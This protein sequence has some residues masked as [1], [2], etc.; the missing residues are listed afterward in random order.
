MAWSRLQSASNTVGSGNGTVTF[1]TN[2]SAGSKIICYIC[3]SVTA[4]GTNHMTSV[5]LNDTAVT[6][7][8]SLAAHQDTAD[9]SWVYLYA[10]DT[11]ADAVGTK[12]TITAT[13]GITDFGI[14][15]LAQ[16]VSGLLAGSTS[17][18][19]DGTPA[20]DSG[21]T[22]GPA[23]TGSYS[24]NASNE[25]LVA[26]Y[27]DPG[28]GVTVTNSSGYTPDANNVNANSD[29]T[30]FVDYKNSGQ[31]AES[32][33]WALS[34]TA[35]WNTILVAFKLAASGPSGP[36]DVPQVTPGQTWLSLFKP[37]Q[38][39]LQPPA[40]PSG[41]Y[42][43]NLPNRADV[44][45]VS[46][47]AAWLRR[48]KPGLAKPP[49]Q[50][51]DQGTVSASGSFALAPLALSGQGAQSSPDVPQ[52]Q[53]GPVWLRLLRPWARPQVPP[54][55]GVQSAAPVTSTGSLALAPLS[56]SGSGGQSSPDVP[57]AQPGPLWLRLFKPGLPKPPPQPPA[58]QAVNA[59]G[60][61]TLASLALSGQGGQS[62]PDQPQAAPGPLWFRLFK[63]WAQ[64][65]VPPLPAT[66]AVNATGSLALAPVTLSGQGAQTSPD[67]P[68]VQPGPSWL[69]FFKPGLPKPV[70]PVP[71]TPAV[72]ATGSL[73]LA[74]LALAGAAGQSSPDQPQ[75]DPGPLWL[76]LFR[77]WLPRPL[78]PVP[79]TPAVNA[80]GS[81]SLAPLS[82]SG[83]GGQTS[84]DVPSVQPGPFWLRI[85]KP[86]LYR[87]VPPPPAVQNV[88][89]TGNLALAPLALSGTAAQT[90]PDQ[91]QASP[92]PAWLRWFKPGLQRPA[93]QVPS[94]SGIQV[95]GSLTLAPLALSGQAGQSSPDLPAIQPGPAWLRLFRPQ[96]PKPPAWQPSAPPPPSISSTG[97]LSLAPLA[98]SGTGNQTSP[99]VPQADPGPFWFR[100]FKPWVQRP[101]PPV[102][103]TP[104]VNASG[105]LALAPLALSGQAAQTSPDV[106]SVQ[107]GPVWS[108]LFRPWLARPVPPPP[109][110]QNVSATGNLALAPLALSG[111]GSVKGGSPDQIQVQP[112]PFWLRIFKPW[113]PR[114]APVNTGRG[115]VTVTS[116]GGITLAPLK[117]SGNA[118]RPTP[119]FTFGPARWA[120]QTGSA[121]WQWATGAAR[122]AWD[123]G[124]GRNE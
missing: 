24:S 35:A 5:A 66:P 101:V 38:Y 103:A 81:L 55:P 113:I 96:A 6:A 74:P 57:Q 71:A 58:V 77:P 21:D 69:R 43:G 15:I 62:S 67:V 32:A 28:Y 63:P 75:A 26:F 97:S 41:P 110:V 112:G 7:L 42:Y 52:I 1:G 109:A 82:L 106:P 23:A 107:P 9:Q 88:S 3:V 79:A 53:P 61:L 25:Y 65:P 122:K 105:S 73:A 4:G 10:V 14:T 34:G 27:G 116:T 98:L 95:S 120:W 59:T 92:G 33:S 90:S 102:P 2:L 85:F 123:A 118:Q 8:T 119:V 44:P 17:A 40:P 117:L 48:F 20:V 36:Q 108:R 115:A 83:S 121:R 22:S 68:Q 91:P 89:A 76:K 31:T 78:P 93:P 16:E 72:N 18:M 45:V 47:G 84:P 64:R 111:S 124:S 100:L 54:L 30:V 39:R 80:T 87:P 114:A 70:P 46:P 11:P 12:P 19:L 29:A 13:Y 49:P 37:G 99:D 51:P 104:A 86:G 50:V 56:L 60:S 94:S